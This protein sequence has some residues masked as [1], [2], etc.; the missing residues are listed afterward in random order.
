[1]QNKLLRN[2]IDKQ[3]KKFISFK[4][5]ELTNIIENLNQKFMRKNQ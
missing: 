5:D 3:G 1:M 4:N 2:D